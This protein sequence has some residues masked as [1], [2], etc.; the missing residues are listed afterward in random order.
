M[1]LW[2]EHTVVSYRTGVVVNGVCGNEKGEEKL[3]QK[4]KKK[5]EC[6]TVSI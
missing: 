1:W 4:K 6:F 5:S 3:L 2:R